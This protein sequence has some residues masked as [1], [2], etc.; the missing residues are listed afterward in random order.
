MESEFLAIDTTSKWNPWFELYTVN[1]V[2]SGTTALDVRCEAWPSDLYY[3][4]NADFIIFGYYFDN[5][6]VG[7]IY[8]YKIS[9][10]KETLLITDVDT[11]DRD[12]PAVIPSPGGGIIYRLYKLK[13]KKSLTFL[14]YPK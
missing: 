11:F 9:T 12:N 6:R 7:E 14:L 10:G 5:Q 1:A 13:L 3:M 8:H 4:K 2:G